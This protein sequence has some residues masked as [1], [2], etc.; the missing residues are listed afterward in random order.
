MTNNPER[1]AA[2]VSAHCGALRDETLSGFC[3]S[4]QISRGSPESIRS[5]PGLIDA[6]PLAFFK[7]AAFALT[8]QMRRVTNAAFRFTPGLQ[9]AFILLRSQSFLVVPMAPIFVQTTLIRACWLEGRNPHI[10]EWQ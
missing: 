8:P 5:N 2:I 4:W 6:T 7:F 10:R 9:I 1:V 3:S